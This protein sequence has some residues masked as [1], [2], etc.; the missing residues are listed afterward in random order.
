MFEKI[1]LVQMVENAQQSNLI[2]SQD[3]QKNLF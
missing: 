2:T 3:Q 1:S